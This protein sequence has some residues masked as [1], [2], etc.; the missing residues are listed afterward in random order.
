[1]TC[2]EI[3]LRRVPPWLMRPTVLLQ[4]FQIHFVLHLAQGLL[5]PSEEKDLMMEEKLPSRQRNF[6]Q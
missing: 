2:V 1:M 5:Q 4:L 3:V 6:E